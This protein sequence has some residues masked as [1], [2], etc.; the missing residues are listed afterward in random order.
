MHNEAGQPS[1][2]KEETIRRNISKME[3]RKL[4]PGRGREKERIKG[5]FTKTSQ[6]LL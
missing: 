3:T 1:H 4:G 2:E 6:D 5:T